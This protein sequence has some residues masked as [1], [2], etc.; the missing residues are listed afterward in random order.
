MAI[1][2]PVE[3]AYLDWLVQ[4][5]Q[6]DEKSILEARNYYNGVQE[7]FMSARVR[8]FLG[9]HEDN[10]F[11]LNVCETVVTAVANVL[12]VTGFDTNEKPNQDGM[13][14]QADWA[15]Q[16]WDANKMDSLQDV[17]HEFAL[18]DRETFVIVDWDPETKMPSLVHNQ[19]FIDVGAGGDGM[20]V[21]MVYENDDIYQRP[22]YA[23]KQWVET[24]WSAGGMPH[25]TTRRTVYYADRIE[26]FVYDA[27]WKPFESENAPA[28]QLQVDKAEQPLGIP[29]IHFKN[30][31]YRAEHWKAIPMQ[32]AINKTLVD[33]LGAN[34]LTAFKSFFALGFM[35]TTDGKAPAADGSNALTIGPGV[36]NGAANVKAGEAALQEIEGADMTP[37][38]NSLKDLV[39]L[40]AQITDTPVSRFIVTAQIASADTIKSQTEALEKKAEDRRGLFGDAWSQVM[41]MA[42]KY[43]NVYGGAG[44]N[45]EIEFKTTWRHDRTLE[46]LEKK[47]T[48]LEIP[49]EQIWVEASYTPEQI[50]TMKAMVEYR[51]ALEKILWEGAQAA[52]LQGIPLELYL[53]RAGVPEKEITAIQEAIANQSGVPATDL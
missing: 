23:V 44:L 34:D 45:E 39:T 26:R 6:A 16:V 22:L 2:D 41:G 18:A 12:N 20:G 40:T 29:V 21:W 3:M 42:R 14:A 28:I 52:S 27:G 15:R 7:D 35:P 24:Q 49:R 10:P 30:K 51:I 46:E 32:D 17:V 33:I 37:L 36:I 5:L 25:T 4:Q 9:V 43:A 31:G 48:A 50:A 19:R 8:Q 11:S 53:Q 38:M 13:K 47:R 1:I